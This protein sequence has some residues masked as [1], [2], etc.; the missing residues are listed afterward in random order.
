MEADWEFEIGQDAPVI[1]ACW[2]GF[3]DLRWTP[4]RDGQISRLLSGIEEAVAFPA[5]GVALDKL[6]SRD[7]PVWT[8]KCDFWPVLEKEAFEPDELDAPPGDGVHGAGCYIDLLPKSD[9]Q[10]P[11]PKL[12]AESCKIVCA[13]LRD[14]SLRCCRVDLVIRRA[15]IAEKCSD[16]GIT[17]YCTACGV[18]AVDARASL[19]CCLGALADAICSS[20]K[21]Q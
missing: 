12:A 19:E 6:N 16:T 11:F 3:I 9:Q 17:A 2:S 13:R 15:L 18:A 14:V 4:Q 1:D 8:S 10:W 20:A 5:L 21:L 7:S